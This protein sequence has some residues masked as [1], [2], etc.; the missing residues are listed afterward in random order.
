MERRSSKYDIII[1]PVDYNKSFLD[2]TPEEIQDYYQWFSLIK[3]ERLAN[4]CG[5]LFSNQQDCLDERNLGVIEMFLLNSVSTMHKPKEQFKTESE[6]IPAALKPYAKPDD[7][8]LDNRTISICFD[9]G[10]YLGDLVISMDNKIKWDLE[11]NDEFAD[12]GQPILAKRSCKL[13]INPFRVVKNIAATVFEETYG[14]R[15]IYTVFEA[16]KKGFNVHH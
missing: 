8:I 5:F 13:K 7:Y 15:N 3:I 14:E 6:Q 2:Y 12:F 9:V 11:T 4:L 10:I 1:L 16:W